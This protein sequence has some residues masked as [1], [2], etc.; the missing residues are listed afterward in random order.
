M[1]PKLIHHALRWYPIHR[2]IR[3]TAALWPSSLSVGNMH[4]NKCLIRTPTIQEEIVAIKIAQLRINQ[5][6]EFRIVLLSN[7]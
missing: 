3:H 1:H 4:L 2:L 7:V 5:A 6:A